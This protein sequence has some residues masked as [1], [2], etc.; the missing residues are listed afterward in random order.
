M[1]FTVGG[2]SGADFHG[3]RGVAGRHRHVQLA[4]GP[5]GTSPGAG[6]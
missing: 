5:L 6:L 3:E 4:A 1:L 2:V